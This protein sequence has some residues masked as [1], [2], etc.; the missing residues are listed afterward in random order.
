LEITQASGNWFN[1][2]HT[3]VVLS[4]LETLTARQKPRSNTSRWRFVTISTWAT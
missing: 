1:E 3:A 4:Q 2:S